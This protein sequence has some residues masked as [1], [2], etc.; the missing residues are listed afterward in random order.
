M[1]ALKK[2]IKQALAKGNT[3][4]LVALLDEAKGSFAVEYTLRLLLNKELGYTVPGLLDAIK[5]TR[6]PAEVV[7]Y[8]TTSGEDIEDVDLSTVG[9]WDDRDVAESNAREQGEAGRL[10]KITA[11]VSTVEELEVER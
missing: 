9:H 8:T 7:L 6:A 10:F 5:A 1:S 3:R 2:K 4:E 11:V